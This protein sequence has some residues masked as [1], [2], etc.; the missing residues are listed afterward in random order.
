MNQFSGWAGRSV[1]QICSDKK[2]KEKDKI[3][4]INDDLKIQHYLVSIAQKDGAACEITFVVP[5][6]STREPKAPRSINKSI[7]LLIAFSRNAKL[8]F[9]HS[10]EN[11]SSAT[12]NGTKQE[13]RHNPRDKAAKQ[14][15]GNRNR[16]LIVTRFNYSIVAN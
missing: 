4:K 8:R 12:M 1:S 13:I 16:N 9:L 5:F 2:R 15:R 14:K 3:G 11:P 7:N 6:P 10:Y